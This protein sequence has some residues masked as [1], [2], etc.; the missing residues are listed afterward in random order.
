MVTENQKQRVWDNAKKIRGKNPNLWRRDQ[1]DNI[2]YKPSYGMC[3]DF[4]WQI[5]HKRPTSKGGS[6]SLRNLQAINTN[7][8]DKKG[9]KYPYKSKKKR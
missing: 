3:G 2:I 7:E 1:Y 5:D 6:D 8:H 4:G 9:K